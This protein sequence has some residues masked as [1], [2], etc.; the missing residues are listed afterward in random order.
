[1]LNRRSYTKDRHTLYKCVSTYV[2]TLK[3]KHLVLYFRS[4]RGKDGTKI[5]R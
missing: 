3:V 2:Y 4:S 5:A 1:M